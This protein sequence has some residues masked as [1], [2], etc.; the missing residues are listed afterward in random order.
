MENT[1]AKP[2]LI[3]TQF[4]ASTINPTHNKPSTSGDLFAPIMIGLMATC[5][6]A[7]FL[8]KEAFK[9]GGG[10]NF[11]LHPAKIP[12]QNCHFFSKNSLLKCAVHPTTAMTT[13]AVGC[14]DYCDRRKKI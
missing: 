5:A 1:E 11:S 13:D 3:Q 2:I 4:E 9:K 12:C 6:I 8:A 14:S 7:L 10:T